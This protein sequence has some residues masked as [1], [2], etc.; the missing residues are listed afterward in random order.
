[1][2]TTFTFT[3]YGPPATAALADAIATAKGDNL[4]APVTV[5]VPSNPDSP[6]RFV[7]WNGM[8]LAICQQ[9]ISVF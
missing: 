6:L 1:M 9:R 2:T 5:V 8:R 7:I 3:A 4:L